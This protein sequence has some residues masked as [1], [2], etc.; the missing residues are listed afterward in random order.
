[1]IL[2]VDE[3][4]EEPLYL[5]IYR[6]ILTAVA[7]GRVEVGTALPSTR[8]LAGD[9]SVNYHTVHKAYDLLRMRGV[10]AMAPRGKAVVSRPDPLGPPDEWLAGWESTMR[11][12]LAEGL[13]V[14]L[15]PGEMGRRCRALLDAVRATAG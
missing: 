6:Q 3:R 11:G 12:L 5:Q 1:V 4:S 14:G 13:A 7:A 9:L 10:I 15:S 8:R 2:V